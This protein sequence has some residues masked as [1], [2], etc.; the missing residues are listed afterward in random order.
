MYQIDVWWLGIDASID[1]C[2]IVTHSKINFKR[3]SILLKKNLDLKWNSLSALKY[4]ILG[5]I[6]LRLNN[7]PP[8]RFY[9]HIILLN[10]TIIIFRI[11]SYC[12]FSTGNMA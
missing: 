3:L 2:K 8:P 10:Y 4:A 5:N 11:I 6:S 9:L 7:T 1:V 12:L